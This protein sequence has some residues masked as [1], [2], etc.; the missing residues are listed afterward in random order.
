MRFLAIGECMAELAP[1]VTA[2]GFSLGFA[3]DT[4]NTAWYLARLRP[5]TSVSFFTAIG[6]DAISQKLRDAITAGGIDDSHVQVV[7]DRTIGLYMISLDNG[8]RSFSYWRSQSAARQLAADPQALE[9]AMD[10][11][12]VIYFS[13]ITLAI[14]DP[15]SRETL[16]AALRH[17]RAAGKTV[18]FD[19]NL[20]PRLWADPAEMTRVVMQGAAVSDIAL[21]SFEDEA[22][23]FGDN[24]PEAT[25]AR[26]A[27]AGASTVVVK[28]GA[29]P[30]FYRQGD[31]H[32]SAA[33][34]ALQSIVDT[35]AAGDSFNAAILAGM[36]DNTPLTHSITRACRLAGS[37]VQ[38]KGAL[39]PVD[40]DG[41]DR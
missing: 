15:A 29:D 18:A 34:P 22:S 2:D 8:E 21:P 23:W 4:F 12:D 11:T 39:I 19:P 16:L 40:S 37:V 31:V 24:D 5:E 33:V 20:R 28:N 7:P 6:A 36:D 41:L 38:S 26:Y 1:A 9:R 25:A 27:D 14:L 30:V 10:Q 32:G 13:G 3:G 17:A 35:T